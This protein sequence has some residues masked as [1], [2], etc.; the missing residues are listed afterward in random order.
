MN[1]KLE[2]RVTS[3]YEHRLACSYHRINKRGIY[4]DVS[5]IE[6]LREKLTKKILGL[7]SDIS[8]EWGCEAYLGNMKMPKGDFNI[9]ASKQ[10]IK[11]LT[12]KGHKVPKIRG[13]DK[14]TA[15]QLALTRLFASS[16]DPAIGK[17]LEIKKVSTVLTR[18]VSARLYNNTFYYQYNV[19]G[20][21]TGRRG[22]TQHIFGW[23]NNAQN[24]PKYTE[25]G[26]EFR[27]CLIARPGKIF[28]AFD[29]M[30]AEDWPVSAYAN[31]GR[32]LQELKSGVD[33]H[34]NLAAFLFSIPL[35]QV[36]KHP[37]RFL[38]KKFRHANNY[39]MGKNTASEN[40]VKDGFAFSPHEC[41]FM[42]DKVNSYDPSI[43]GVFHKDV[44]NRLSKERKL[45]TPFGRERYFLGLRPKDHNVKTFM[46]AYAYGPQSIVGDNTGFAVLYLD[47]LGAP[48]ISESHDS[49]IIE[50]DDDL[51]TILRWRDAFVSAFDREIIINGHVIKIPIEGELG[52]NLKTTKEM[53]PE[54]PDFI[55]TDKLVKDAWLAIRDGRDKELDAKKATGTVVVGVP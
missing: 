1:D 48:I 39:G 34:K 45:V 51:D 40:L 37:H 19:S 4:V 6:K 24:F 55:I 47:G 54:A 41:Q 11:M 43:K 23:G 28:L 53:K 21:L 10:L 36:K 7:C 32:A 35:D 44:E 27:E 33:R 31:N 8:K 12:D 17:I 15:N 14:E 49:I 3:S 13:E 5:H 50:I 52:Y 46:E 29:Q 42:L 9:N 26:L 2:S 25:L 38:G 16:N 30:Q 18:Y 22:C 20:T